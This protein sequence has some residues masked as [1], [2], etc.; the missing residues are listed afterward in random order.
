[1]ARVVFA[2]LDMVLAFEG[3]SLMQPGQAVN[4]RCGP[5]APEATPGGAGEA[6]GRADRAPPQSAG[7]ANQ[8]PMANGA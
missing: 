1:M 5:A 3:N 6:G 4:R 2:M 8:Q 7:A